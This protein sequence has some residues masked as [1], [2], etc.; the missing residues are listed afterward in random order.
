[1]SRQSKPLDFS[2]DDALALAF[3]RQK[4]LHNE[5]S[6]LDR[7]VTRRDLGVTWSSLSTE[8]YEI[9]RRHS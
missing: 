9:D 1:M 6:W 5:V 2:E 3:R 4:Q 7:V 8:S